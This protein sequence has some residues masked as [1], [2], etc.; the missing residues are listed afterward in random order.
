MKSLYRPSWLAI[1]SSC[2]LNT[3]ERCFLRDPR[4]VSK[5][6][7][8]LIW[9]T[10]KAVAW[11]SPIYQAC[12]GLE[13]NT[14]FLLKCTTDTSTVKSIR[15]RKT[16]LH[17]LHSFPNPPELII[18]GALAAPVHTKPKW[19]LN[20]HLAHSTGTAGSILKQS[21]ARELCPQ[22][23]VIPQVIP[24]YWKSRIHLQ[25]KNSL[26]KKSLFFEERIKTK[27]NQPRY[28]RKTACHT[29]NVTKTCFQLKH[30]KTLSL[31]GL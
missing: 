14:V 13:I 29:G 28:S 25:P 31:L 23:Q 15:I 5:H 4:K 22:Q 18:Q 3:L 12:F 24:F 1:L 8:F 17:L 10:G 20:L 16:I 2:A 6:K 30:G 7:K 19:A 9:M 11:N 26:E 27:N 21:W